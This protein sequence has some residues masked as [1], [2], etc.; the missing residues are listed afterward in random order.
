MIKK[1]SGLGFLSASLQFFIT[2]LISIFVLSGKFGKWLSKRQFALI[3]TSLIL[4][5]VLLFINRGIDER[6]RSI[7]HGFWGTLF[8]AI[9]LQIGRAHV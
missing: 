6:I 7:K 3:V 5:T 8:Q 2:F 9:T 1:F 4:S